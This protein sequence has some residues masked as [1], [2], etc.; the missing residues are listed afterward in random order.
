MM[1]P[2]KDFA[3]GS[4]SRAMNIAGQTFHRMTAIEPVGRSRDRAIVWRFKCECGNSLNVPATRVVNGHVKSCGCQRSQ[5]AKRH[6]VDL[7]GAI[8]GRLEVIERAGSNQYG[9]AQWRCRCDCGN[10]IV[11][12]G[13]SLR[14]GATQSCGCLKI[15]MLVATARSRSLSEEEKEASRIRRRALHAEWTS[16]RRASDPVYRASQSLGSCLK[17]A[18]KRI[19][20]N[21]T[22]ATFRLLPYTP[23]ELKIHLE[24]QFRRGMS[25]DNYGEWQIDHIVPL[26]EAR[27]LDDVLRLNE[28][29]NLRP[30]WKLENM[31]KNGRRAFLC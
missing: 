31:K 29:P 21:K 4:P 24:R 20:E 23:S 5:S 7:V 11:T 27:S 13:N 15:S 6:A 12:T 28:L 9:A 1:K 26:C 16:A 14:R 22:A 30:L 3:G 8:F 18:L 19:N 2:G 10:D 25:W 17:F